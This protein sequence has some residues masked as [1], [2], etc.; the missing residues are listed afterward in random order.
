MSFVRSRVAPAT[1][2]LAVLASGLALS[3]PSVHGQGA[4]QVGRPLE[5]TL[6][7]L[8]EHVLPRTAVVYGAIGLGTGAVVDHHGTVVTNAHVA[9]AAR[10]AIL[11]FAD[12]RRVVARRRGIDF[13]KDLAVL[14]PEEPL[15]APVPCFGMGNGT[16]PAVGAW[17]AAVGYPGGPRGDLRPTF[18]LGQVVAGGGLASPIGGILDYSDAI[19]TDIAIYEG[20]SGGPLVDLDGRL[21]GI[22][23][24]FEPG[25]G[26]AFAIPLDVVL[27]RVRTLHHGVVR[28]PNGIELDERNPIVEALGKTLD[29]IVRQLVERVH[30][31]FD[32]LPRSEVDGG[33]E[34]SREPDEGAEA[35]EKVVTAERA[36]PRSKAL[37]DAFTDS[38]PRARALALRLEGGVLATRVDSSHA[39][40][41]ATLVVS[42]PDWAVEGGGHAR[43]LGTSADNDLALL[44]LDGVPE[45]KLPSD[46]GARPAGSIVAA[47]GPSGLLGA[48]VVSVGAR[49]IPDAVSQRIAGNGAQQKKILQLVKRLKPIASRLGPI[50]NLLEE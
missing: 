27:E 34:K 35:R 11:E 14:E 32:P 18:S 1:T 48:G 25:T 33:E 19:R 30:E 13:T 45:A 9:L 42:R 43:V 2:A 41:K 8:A 39:V 17:V 4:P 12:G 7:S 31:G 26:S 10:V 50:G 49:V 6:V 40:T 29:P 24:A 23:G 47:V 3:S 22:N 28:L 16:R 37:A 44:E 15:T 20:N 46:A 21:Q 38:L 5:R 36:S